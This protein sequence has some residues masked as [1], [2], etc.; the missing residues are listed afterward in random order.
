LEQEL[1]E[2]VK[3]LISACKGDFA[4]PAVTVNA[5]SVK[6]VAKKEGSK[7]NGQANDD[8]D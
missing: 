2:E 6:K 5:V 3:R 7:Q 1:L 4:D 8:N